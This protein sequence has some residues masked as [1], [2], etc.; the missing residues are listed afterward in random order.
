MIIVGVNWTEEVGN[1]FA[2]CVWLPVKFTSHV[3]VFPW[4]VVYLNHYVVLFYLF[5][6]KK[7]Y[8]VAE[9]RA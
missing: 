7:L 2:G 1:I 9:A 4:R 5:H 3:H 8:T 6:L